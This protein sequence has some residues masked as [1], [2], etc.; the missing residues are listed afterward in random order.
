M[1]IS[2]TSAAA[3]HVS[4]QLQAR[5]RGEGIR[6]GV[7]TSG[8]SGLAYVLEFVDVQDP[9]DTLFETDGLRVF[10]DPKS[11]VYLDG[12][13]IDFAKE[14][15]NEGLEFRN[16]NVAAECGCGESFTV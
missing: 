1:A 16:P 11:L 7:K 9:E 14:G 4:K 5:G 2:V 3:E 12:T 6:I 13:I 15:L 10:V 8:C